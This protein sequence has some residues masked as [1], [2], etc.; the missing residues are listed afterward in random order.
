MSDDLSQHDVLP[1][2]LQS[3]LDRKLAPNEKV[4]MTLAGASGEGLVVT[5][6][7]VV[8]LREQMGVVGGAAGV[9][10]FDH[11]YE[12]IQNVSVEGAV[13]GGHLK[14]ILLNQPTDE[15][16]VTLFFPSYDLAKFDAAAARIRLLAEQTRGV[17]AS[18][19]TAADLL[20]TPAPSGGSYAVCAVCGA[21][22][23]PTHIFCGACGAP[24]G[25]A[26]RYCFMPVPRAARFCSYCGNSAA[27]ARELYCEACKQP[28]S[29][30]YLYCPRCGASQGRH[31]PH[32]GAHAHGTWVRCAQCGSALDA[33]GTTG[34]PG[35]AAP[36]TPSTVSVILPTQPAGSSGPGSTAVSDSD[37]AAAE[38]H[39]AR[40]MELYEQ[41]KLPEA[42]QEFERALDLAPGTPLYHCNLGVVYADMGRDDDAIEEYE[43]AIR[44]APDDPTAYL[45][46][47]YFHSERENAAEAERMWSKVSEVAP[48]SPE[49]EEARQNLAHEDEL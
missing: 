23:Q 20:S 45:N 31:C 11:F 44:L 6:S 8:I 39:N 25:R 19:V 1:L 46:L 33:S 38:Q 26:C 36:S 16:Q 7:R 12:Q 4:L 28:V 21:A 34:R 13:G 14:L 5:D 18:T 43:T 49:A 40:G 17:P 9:D 29:V 37:R 35:A 47:G 2:A 15:H 24:Q 3:A 42:L 48:D 41:E 32:C 10:C 22:V 27:D 30:N